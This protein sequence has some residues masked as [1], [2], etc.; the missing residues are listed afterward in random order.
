MSFGR[1]HHREHS[2]KHP[3]RLLACVY[4]KASRSI[5]RQGDPLCQDERLLLVSQMARRFDHQTY[6]QRWQ[7][8]TVAS[9]LRPQ[10][11]LRLARSNSL[12]P[13]P[14]NASPR[15]H[16]QHHDS[17]TM[18]ETF[19]RSKNIPFPP[20]FS[21]KSYGRRWHIET[22]LSGLKRTNGRKLSARLPQAMFTEANFRFVAYA[23]RL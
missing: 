6:G 2:L 3:R 20:T 7:V 16:A 21:P 22:F 10:S 4:T 1:Y 14:R 17:V 11:R 18:L 9:M 5:L 13:M 23:L 19:L 12:E 15:P 8:E